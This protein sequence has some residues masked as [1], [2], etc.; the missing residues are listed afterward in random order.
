LYRAGGLTDEQ[1]TNRINNNMMK[2][3]TREQQMKANKM[4]M[5]YIDLRIKPR[6]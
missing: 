6:E 3:Y 1:K 4:G 5:C 2:L